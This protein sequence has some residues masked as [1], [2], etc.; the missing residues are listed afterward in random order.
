LALKKF[1]KDPNGKLDYVLDWSAWLSPFSDQ[2][3]SAT[4]NVVPTGGLSI[5]GTPGGTFSNSAQV[6]LSNSQTLATLWASGGVAGSSYD[7]T[8]RVTTVGG[9]IDDRT[10]TI[11][12]KE[13]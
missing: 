13:M 10:V 5:G 9:R 3:S 6:T 4:A 2:I 1:I 8:V 12:C 7:V 11:T